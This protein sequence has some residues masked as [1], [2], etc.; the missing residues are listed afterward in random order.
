MQLE[1]N[2]LAANKTWILVHP[3]PSQH[4][5][6]CKWVFKIK[7]RA[8]DTIERYKARLVVK[9]YHQQGVD[10]NETFSPVVCPTTI[11]LVFSLAISQQ[12]HVRQLDVQNAFL[13]GDLL[14]PVYMQQPPRFI[15]STHPDHVCLLS[16]SL[17]GLKQS[18]RA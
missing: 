2:A 4:V 17:Y 12:W 6:G 5:V 3:P 18:L 14:E 1:I 11:Y 9:G 7:K 10:Y 16:K 15:D 13:H 8:D